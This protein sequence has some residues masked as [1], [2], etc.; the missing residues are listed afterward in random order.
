LTKQNPQQLTLFLQTF[1]RFLR[2][3]YAGGGLLLLATLAAIFLANGPFSAPYHQLL[4]YPLTLRVGPLQVNESAR[5][6]INSTLMA[7][8]FLS[9]GL[10]IKRELVLGSLSSAR[11][12]A[13]PVAGAVGGMLVPALIFAFLN[14]Q[15]LSITGWAIPMATDPAFAI[16][17]LTVLRNRI[18][19]GLRAF[20]VT[21]TVV[22]DIGAT[23]VIALVYHEGFV[24]FPALI[25]LVIVILLLMTNKAGV[26][27]LLPYLLLGFFLWAAFIESGI[28]TSVAGVILALT[29]PVRA[30][31][32]G[33]DAPLARLE[34]ALVPW[35]TYLI[36]PVLALSNA[37]ILFQDTSLSTI[38]LTPLVSGIFLGLLVGKPLGITAAC[39]AAVFLRVAHLPKGVGW[40]HL[41][42]AGLLGG[43]GFTTSIFLA[44]LAFTGEA[45]FE[46]SKIGILPASIS[47]AISGWLLLTMTSRT[48]TENQ[49]I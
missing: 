27:S 22:D 20:L 49:S 40:T 32:K 48:E 14:W 17:I 25:G 19:A 16:A 6:W 8:F 12:A 15:Q 46:Y 37:G 13:L 9:V 42:G 3:D 38:F 30:R 2:S 28:H 39:L 24:L 7:L 36:L 10:E 1:Q 26:Q 31:H 33:Q 29:I 34:H 21:L 41:A 5:E 45:L 35:V 4:E 44:N 47:A 11:K 23:I 43:I 18:P